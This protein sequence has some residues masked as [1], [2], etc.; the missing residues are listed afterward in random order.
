[1]DKGKFNRRFTACF[2]TS[3]ITLTDWLPVYVGMTFSMANT[4]VDLD[5]LRIGNAESDKPVGSSDDRRVIMDL[6]NGRIQIHHCAIGCP[7]PQIA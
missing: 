7:G 6:K 5:G 3:P 2:N 4:D 1:M